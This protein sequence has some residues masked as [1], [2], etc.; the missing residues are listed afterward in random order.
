LGADAKSIST[1][2]V[3]EGQMH[4]SLMAVVLCIFAHASL[5][6]IPATDAAQQAAAPIKVHTIKS[7]TTAPA[8]PGTG[9]ITTAAAGTRD[10]PVSRPAPRATAQPDE[11]HP[12]RA[13]PA[14]LLAALA[15]M[16]GIALRR[17]G[18]GGQ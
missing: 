16:S 18:A 14:M 12:R 8:L 11:E 3:K 15:L 9:L 17:Y 7:Q 10:A 5:A 4:S 6:C 1:S 2:T 13:G